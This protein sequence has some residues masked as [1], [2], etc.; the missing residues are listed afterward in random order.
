[1]ESIYLMKMSSRRRLR[2]LLHQLLWPAAS[3]PHYGPE[4]MLGI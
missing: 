2:R 4:P 3:V 1:M